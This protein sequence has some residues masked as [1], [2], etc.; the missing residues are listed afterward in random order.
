MLGLLTAVVAAEGQAQRP[1]Q[2]DPRLPRR[3]GAIAAVSGAPVAG[4]PFT[5][6]EV[7]A[8]IKNLMD[9]AEEGIARSDWKYAIDSLQR[10]IDNPEG[11]LML[12][13]GAPGE[14]EVYESARQRA[15][16]RLASLP[17]EGIAAY[18]VLYDGR[19]KGMVERSAA[20]RD[21]A[22]LR[23][24]V[25]R[26]PLTSYADE[27]AELLASWALDEGRAAEAAGLLE[28]IALTHPDSDLPTER[29]R[30]KLAAAYAR[31]GRLED[32]QEQVAR[33]GVEESDRHRGWLR[34]VVAGVT[35]YEEH[36]RGVR[37]ES[38]EWPMTGGSPQRLGVMSAVS[39]RLDR[40]APWW[41]EQ[42]TV[43][44]SYWARQAEGDV[45]SLPLPAA[46]VVA[47]GGR[48]FVRTGRG[49]AALDAEDLS[50]IWEAPLAQENTVMARAALRRGASR[51]VRD[52]G[53]LP[54]R[55][56]D[57]EIG[58]GLAV[59]HGL[60]FTVENHG[61]SA[62]T[63]DRA[64]GVVLPPV[65]VLNTPSV[66]PRST[67]LA[68]RDVRTGALRWSRGRGTQVTDPLGTVDFRGLPIP[69][70]SELWV[71]Y[72]RQSD[73]LIAVLD[74]QDGAL[75]QSILLC[76]VL[77]P[78]AVVD[79]AVHL[80][81]CEGVVYAASGHGVAFAVDVAE[82]APIWASAYV[83]TW[84]GGPRHVVAD[85][86]QG[87]PRLSSAPVVAGGLV[88]V[89]P[90][91]RT[92]MVA[93]DRITGEVRWRLALDA[94]S[95]VIASRGGMF[96]LGGRELTCRRAT[97][98]GVVWHRKLT[99]PATGR[100][101][102][103]GDRL[104]LPTLSGVMVVDAE[105]GDVAAAHT[106]PYP[107]TPLGQLLSYRSSLYSYDSIGVRRF[108]DLERLYPEALHD[109][110]S[111]PGDAQAAVRL[112]RLELLRDAPEQAR[113]VLRKV[114]AEGVEN[115]RVAAAAAKTQVRA[116]LML[117]ERGGE[118]ADVAGFLEEA[119]HAAWDAQD[120]LTCALARSA[121]RAK[122]GEA[123]DAAEVLWE[124]GLHPD[125]SAMRTIGQGVTGQ[126]RLELAAR[127]EELL[128]AGGEAARARVAAAARAALEEADARLSGTTRR[129][130]LRLWRAIADLPSASGS[131]ETALL[132]LAS[133]LSED[134]EQLEAAEQALLE[135]RRRTTAGG[136]A[137]AALMRLVDLRMALPFGPSL[138]VAGFLEEL[139]RE[140]GEATVPESAYAFPPGTGVREW[141]VEKRRHLPAEMAGLT[142]KPPAS[143]RVLD[144][145]PLW[146]WSPGAATSPNQLPTTPR[147]LPRPV[148]F[149]DPAQGILS[150]RML[151]YDDEDEA[152]LA[153]DLS[154][155]SLLWHVPLRRPGT[156]DSSNAPWKNEVVTA[157]RRAGY[158][159]QTAVLCG[160]EGTFAVGLLTGKRLW[161]RP[162]ETTTPYG[163]QGVREVTTAV[164]AGMVF[165]M[166][167][168]GRLTAQR[169]A[170]GEVL[171]ERD[172]RT[173]PVTYV[174]FLWGAV[175]LLDDWLERVTLL[176][177]R[178]GRRIQSMRFRQP[179]PKRVI[180]GLVHSDG[181]LCGPD[182]AA[183][184][185]DEVVGYSVSSG[186]PV[187][188]VGLDK[189]LSGLFEPGPGFVGISLL[190]GEVRIV[191][192]RDG[193]T[194]L[195]RAL[196]GVQQ[197][198]DGLMYDGLLL[199]RHFSGA[200]GPRSSELIALDIATGETLWRRGDVRALAGMNDELRV[201][202]G[203]LVAA[204]EYLPEG[205]NHRLK[206]IGV[207]VLDARTGETMG[208]VVD[209]PQVD[210]RMHFDGEIMVWPGAVVVQVREIMQG[211]ALKPMT[212]AAGG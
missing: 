208:P 56:A 167:R 54:S 47:T 106:L 61:Q 112:A 135:C 97:D 85:D 211:F 136:Y 22:G 113:E 174:R 152:M 139:E 86:E 119:L 92:E 199:M 32:A 198:A 207:A 188:R 131:M 162:F 209:V 49:C 137:A 154:D 35:A 57:D 1:I 194:V 80:T 171:W 203:Q 83:E 15:V 88:L 157:L 129:D 73:L 10:I 67:R 121:H 193:E 200:M 77:N 163:H 186:D 53:E 138:D 177:P 55:T 105:R 63:G 212:A 78:Q 175:A 27:A 2:V 45:D 151:L 179:N 126:G 192:A 50:L 120:R 148:R 66:P 89:T 34:E 7:S 202:G 69:V 81:L 150:H 173:E 144:P 196:S 183:D 180:V 9:R 95:Y 94:D 26:Y 101:V 14:G 19:A 143:F 23:A 42:Q 205:S 149:P 76:A 3:P 108:V 172:V 6:V 29:V 178:D 18:R 33:L 195:T 206:R 128:A 185:G 123:A 41:Y 28:G 153:V 187:W 30:G 133:A 104:F 204:V 111:N 51:I 74:P 21:T 38:A 37:L 168:A 59:A 115:E 165:S 124:A 71:P 17:P 169:L 170:D 4:A 118:T 16:R 122:E 48:L 68:A 134:H 191:R 190:G 65:W 58:G 20:S 84:R 44:Y 8:P 114:V 70:G 5:I 91:D 100:A 161:H 64:E 43:E 210:P 60:V 82:R 116:C 25:Q 109:H 158:D 197:V 79:R 90:P 160:Y 201:M 117:A 12:R 146:T 62:S 87:R 102:L 181:V 24:V 103:A 98:R 36:M 130:S 142:A 52:K 182:R 11:S 96:W 155:R 31:L 156:F 141:V 93:L 107:S 72:I 184:G 164:G 125:A 176:S 110:E 39:P 132:R 189:P 75:K 159:G 166:P 140:Y 13:D 147:R 40:E 99:E 46:Q 127:L 145:T